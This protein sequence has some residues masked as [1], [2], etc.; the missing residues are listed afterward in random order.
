MLKCRTST[1][2]KP[3]TKI[4]WLRN[5]QPVR[6]G[7][8]DK[9]HEE[10]ER[11]L[12]TTESTL[13]LFVKLD[14]QTSV[15][16][17]RARHPGSGDKD[18]SDEIKLSVLY[19]PGKPDID[20]Y[21]V[22]DILHAGDKLVVTCMSRGGNPQASLIWY[23]EKELVDSSS[24]SSSDGSLKETTNVYSF[25]V[26]PEDNKR[27]LRCEASNPIGSLSSHIKLNVHFA[28]VNIKINGP[29]VGR[30]NDILRYEC[31]I[32]PSNP[33]PGEINWLIN[34]VQ[35]YEGKYPVESWQE[36]ISFGF[37]SRTNITILLSESIK[38]VACFASSPS[39]DFTSIQASVN[40][41]ILCK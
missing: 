10:E 7:V 33:L 27:Q 23:Q 5:G 4:S 1:S 21:A 34:G 40:V 31:I 30:I 13:H 3:A 26:K 32:G 25:I 16:K 38:T 22:S 29:A 39:S 15:Y 17:C 24:T 18:I 9:V 14:D 28:P 11:T 37:M 20:G 6:E 8:Q 36:E 2:T 19:G 41:H 12:F 35:H